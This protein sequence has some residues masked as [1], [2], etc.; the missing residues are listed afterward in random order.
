[1]TEDLNVPTA[2][3]VLIRGGVL[4]YPTEAV[5]G[6]GCIPFDGEA[7]HRLLAIKR[8]PVDKGLILV[9]AATDQL[10]AVV[11]WSALDDTARGRVA[12]SWPGPHTWV[13]PATTAA[14]PW[15][16]GGRPDIA[17]RV[18]AHPVVA[19]LCARLGG[20]I[21]STSANLTGEPPAFR[22]GELSEALLALA[23]GVCAGET[24][25]LA[26]P[27]PIRVARTGDVLRE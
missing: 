23:D 21:V 4:A 3:A 9:A 2:V 18:S 1:M 27:T 13:V 8:R 17:V 24:G 5:W 26:A 7:V 19:E 20:P 6:L 10:D 11:D 15:V 22:R 14:P 25:G 12:A 16:T